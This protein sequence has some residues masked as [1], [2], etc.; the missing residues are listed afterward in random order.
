MRK[1]NLLLIMAIMAMMF[2]VGCDTEHHDSV[3]PSS[4][5]TVVVLVWKGS[6]S[7]APSNPQTNWAYYNTADKKS[8]IYG[9]ADIGSRWRER[10]QR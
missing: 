4:G 2:I 10:R 5:T 9:V 7:S 6:L 3:N 8:Y 1:I